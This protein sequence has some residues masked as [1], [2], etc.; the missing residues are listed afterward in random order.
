MSEKKTPHFYIN[1]YEQLIRK[2]PLDNIGFL[3]DSISKSI[4]T[5]FSKFE[6]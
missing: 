2:L 1:T 4:S 6:I 3:Q 5:A